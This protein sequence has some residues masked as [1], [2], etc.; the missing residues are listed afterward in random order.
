MDLRLL[1]EEALKE[2]ER[3][4][5]ETRGTVPDQDSDEWE[6]EYRRRFDALKRRP[7]AP[8]VAAAASPVEEKSDALPQLT[9]PPGEQRWAIAIRADRLKE[10]RN[11]DMR[12]WLAGAWTAAK[13]WVGT[14]ELSG[15]A[16][17]RRVEVQYVD[18]RQKS[19]VLTAA[20]KN[21]QQAKAQAAASIHQKVAAAGITAEGLIG[22]IDVSARGKPAPL[23]EKLADIG[24]GE[25]ALRVFE[26][27]D[28]AVLMVLEKNRSGR[29]EYAIERDDG[30]VADLKLYALD[31][32]A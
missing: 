5:R 6:E 4:F 13:D 17:L 22:L 23:R 1:K 14:R 12:R 11:P 29:I 19:Q 3:F 18:E 9:G 8:T 27:G 7:A 28:A 15:P 16:F 30:L 25:R 21:E 24:H 2:T 20:Q 31:R 10:I 26:T 32:R